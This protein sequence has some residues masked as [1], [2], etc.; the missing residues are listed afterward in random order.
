ME[1]SRIIILIVLYFFAGI[2]IVNQ[3]ER[4]VV[5]TFGKYAG[6]LQPWFRFIWPIIQTSLKVDI[7]EKAVDVPSQEA[8]TKDNVSCMI[9]AVIYY[10]IKE[11]RVDR[12]VL[13]VRYLDYAMTQFAQTTMRNIVGQFELDELLAKREEASNKIKEIVDEKSN[14]WWVDVLSVELKDINIPDD[15]KRMIG[16]QAEAEREKRAKIITSEW[17]LA[18]SENL[19]NAAEMLAK[20]P[21]ALHLRTLQSIN[22]ISSDQSNTTVWMIPIEIMQAIQGIKDSLDRK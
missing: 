17:E 4:R 3:F 5:F 16:K 11:E 21:G 6:I 19:K 8:M 10:K 22:D 14:S 7:R 18:S 9:N 1:N 2:R 13:N 15:L 12:S 20:A